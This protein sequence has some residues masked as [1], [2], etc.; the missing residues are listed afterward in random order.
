MSVFGFATTATGQTGLPLY[1]MICGRTV[2]F[3]YGNGNQI[4]YMRAD[5]AAFFWQYR[6]ER[7]I[8]GNWRIRVTNGIQDGV[9]F[10]YKPGSINPTYGG[11]EFCHE[12]GRF[13]ELIS[14]DG[15]VEGDRY[16]LQSGVPPFIMP[17]HPR[18]PPVGLAEQYPEQPRDPACFA[19]VS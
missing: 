12:G 11:H 15:L 19:A 16:D 6:Q 4:E 3:Y 13:L 17:S 1:D 2:H 7:V 5:G 10:Q 18:M 8:E 9:C 14:P